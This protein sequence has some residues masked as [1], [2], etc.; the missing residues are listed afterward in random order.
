MFARREAKPRIQQRDWLAKTFAALST[1]HVAEFLVSLRV[2]RTNSPSAKRALGNVFPKPKDRPK[3]TQVKGIVYK[4]KC[5]S[6]DFTYVGD[7]KT[8]N[9]S[10]AN[11][12]FCL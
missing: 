12:F 6:C 3:E 8:T 2:A 10:E 9:I 7:S 4:F 5:K 1:I 11:F